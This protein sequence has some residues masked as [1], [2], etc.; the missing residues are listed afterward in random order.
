MT[1]NASVSCTHL[2]WCD[3]R[4]VEATKVAAP[5]SEEDDFAWQFWN[6]EDAIAWLRSGSAEEDE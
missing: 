4:W 6:A 1:S 5:W 3:D 2:L